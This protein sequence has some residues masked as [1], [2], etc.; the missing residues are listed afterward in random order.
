MKAFDLANFDG[1]LGNSQVVNEIR[2]IE[3]ERSSWMNAMVQSHTLADQ[4]KK[5]VGADSAADQMAKQFREAQK[6]QEERREWL[7]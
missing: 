5:M 6:T 4:M 2:K 3:R 7:T 1:L